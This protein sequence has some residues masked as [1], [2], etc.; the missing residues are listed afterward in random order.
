MADLPNIDINKVKETASGALDA[1]SKN[2]QAN[3][4]FEK[5]AGAVENK[6]GVD[7]PS[8][9]DLSKMIGQ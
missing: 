6:T 7:I 2:E 1:V 8:A 4:V 9:G 5:A 3:D